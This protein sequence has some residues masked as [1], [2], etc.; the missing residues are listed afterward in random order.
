MSLIKVLSK[1]S[2]TSLMLYYDN[3]LL[4]DEEDHQIFLLHMKELIQNNGVEEFSVV[5][6]NKLFKNIDEKLFSENENYVIDFSTRKIIGFVN[7]FP[8]FKLF[9]KSPS[10]KT[11]DPQDESNEKEMYSHL[12]IKKISFF[13]NYEE[14]LMS[15]YTEEEY[16]SYKN[17]ESN[18]VIF[19]FCPTYLTKDFDYIKYWSKMKEFKTP[20]VLSGKVVTGFQRGSRQLGVPTANM[21][22]NK[23][24]SE[25]IIDMLSGIYVGKGHFKSN[26]EKNPGIDLEKEYKCVLSIGWNP[27]YDNSLKT[28]EVYIID[29]EGENFYNEELEISINSFI[30]TEANFENFGELV[31]AITYDIIQANNMTLL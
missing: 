25:R 2:R 5:S 11:F 16:K 28:I 19:K 12:M 23:Q 4:I 20:I 26:L 31:T 22:M 6:E 21:E 8:N 18:Q 29:Y 14:F 13:T 7:R 24:N 17:Y 30:R 10:K 9:Y 3:K 15:F 27:Y 1:R